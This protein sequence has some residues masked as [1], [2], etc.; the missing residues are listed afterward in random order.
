MTHAPEPAWE[1][2]SPQDLLAFLQPRL[3]AASGPDDVAALMAPLASDSAWVHL[4]GSGARQQLFRL[5]GDVR[6]VF[7]F[8]GTDRLVAY[9][10][11]RGTEPWE[12]GGDD[13]PLM[14]AGPD[15]PLIFV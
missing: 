13:T 11:W 15:V 14:P 7:Q 1:M 4:G 5:P 2:T 8:D 9:G 6:A 10:A 3:S 12:V